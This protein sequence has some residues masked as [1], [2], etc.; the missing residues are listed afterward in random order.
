MEKRS[1]EKVY[2]K[3]AAESDDFRI[4]FDET[5]D[6]W[7]ILYVGG[8]IPEVIHREES[9]P[10]AKV[11]MESLQEALPDNPWVAVDPQYG[12]AMAVGCGR[13]GAEL[14]AREETGLPGDCYDRMPATPTLA[15]KVMAPES[16]PVRIARLSDGTAC[17]MAEE[18]VA[19]ATGRK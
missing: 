5:T 7:A 10:A 14:A 15:A 1:A 18:E 8:R 6:S 16:Y 17:T 11:A 4:V 13:D 12:F 9:F 2:G 19:L 3:A